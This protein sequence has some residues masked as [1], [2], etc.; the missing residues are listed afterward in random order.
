VSVSVWQETKAVARLAG[1]VA[2]AQLGITA[3]GLV[4]VAVLGR[5]SSVDLGG[6][7]VGR[8]LGFA[9]IALGM[10]VAAALEPLAA[11]AVGARDHEAAWRALLAGIVGCVV[12]WL[13]CAAGAV[14]A[15]WALGPIGVEADLVV[16]ARSFLLPQLP[17]MLAFSVFLAAKA[18]L[19]AHERTRPAL[20]AVVLANA[21]NVVVSNLL[22]RGDGALVAVGL[23]PRGLPKLGATG[24]GIANTIAMT[25][26]AAWVLVAA[27][28]MR[29]ARPFTADSTL[30]NLPIAKAFRIGVPIGLQLLAEIGVFSLVSVLAGRLGRVVVSAHQIALG[31][32]SFT[33]MGALG[34][35]GATAVRVGH[36]VGEGRSARPAGLVGVGLSAVYM[37]F[38][39][40]VFLAAREPLVAAFTDDPEVVAL[41]ASLL[42]VAAAFQL[43]DGVQ[44]VAAGALRGAADVRFAF[45]ANAVAHW[46][47]GLPLALWLGFHAGL[48]AR[49]LWIGLLLGLALVAVALL[50]RFVAIAKEPIARA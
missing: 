8:A 3:I 40:M 42:G 31:L 9:G 47:V 44:V 26:L 32:A 35:S 45:L 33:F 39:A 15:T 11:Q 38:A 30:R 23:A 12:A 6:A 20:V 22:V 2:L 46:F 36:A 48:G 4:D 49:G 7:A 43:F 18:F 13:P 24:A 5:A 50:W 41:G 27:W 28:R 37:S 19:Q 34:I 17:G 10:G 29:P 14:G 25:T 16:A 1:P 21:V